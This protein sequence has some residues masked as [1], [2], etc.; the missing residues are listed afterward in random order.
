LYKRVL[1]AGRDY[2]TGLDH[3]KEKW[4]KAIL[5]HRNCPACYVV[6]V[7]YIDAKLTTCSHKGI[8]PDLLQKTTTGKLQLD[9]KECHD[10]ILHAVNRGRRMVKEMIG[11]IQLKKYRSMKQR[12]GTTYNDDDVQ[13]ALDIH[14]D[15]VKE[16]RT[17][18][19]LR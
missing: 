12:Y 4:K 13:S 10:E 11:I 5:D 8:A 17:T 18:G 19:H 1:L 2:P 15:V 14:N 16:T 9:S 7:G 6:D 3:V